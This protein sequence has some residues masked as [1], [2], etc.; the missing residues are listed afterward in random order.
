[1][2]VALV[3]HRPMFYMDGSTAVFVGPRR[4]AGLDDVGDAVVGELPF[5]QAVSMEEAQ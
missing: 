1:M 5:V 2:V 3:D 4:V